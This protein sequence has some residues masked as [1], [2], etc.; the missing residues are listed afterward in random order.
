MSSRGSASRNQH[1]ERVRL[2]FPASVFGDGR[3]IISRVD[4]GN[5]V[6]S[7]QA[8][9]RADFGCKRVSQPYAV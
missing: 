9:L 4:A 3:D 7:S 5:L 8:G 2:A 1:R 6:R